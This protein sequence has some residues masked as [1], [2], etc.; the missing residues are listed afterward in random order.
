[1]PINMTG[2]GGKSWVFRRAA[3][4]FVVTISIMGIS[5]LEQRCGLSP[6]IAF[7]RLIFYLQVLARFRHRVYNWGLLSGRSSRVT[8]HF[9]LS[10]R[11]GTNQKFTH[12]LV[13][14]GQQQQQQQ[15]A[16]AQAV[17]PDGPRQV[18]DKLP[19]RRGGG[20]GGGRRR[21]RRRGRGRRLRRAVRGGGGFVRDG[22]VLVR[23]FVVVRGGRIKVL[24]YVHFFSCLSAVSFPLFPKEGGPTVV[25]MEAAAS[26][27]S[28]GAPGWP[29]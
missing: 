20:G 22:R 21:W 11:K 12:L 2:G 29:I 1:M 26:A 4:S 13:G 19:V 16:A 27:S 6:A 5:A 18:L 14:R 3:A 10:P 23:V 9:R 15:R 24:S 17:S 28:S 25:E 8:Q 7:Y